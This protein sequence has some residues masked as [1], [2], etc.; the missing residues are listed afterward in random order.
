[1]TQD[2]HIASHFISEPITIH[3]VEPPIHT[4]K[5]HCPDR[6]N[7]RGEEWIITACLAEWVDYT[8]R[9][10][11]AKNMQAQHAQVASQHGSWGV[12]R[13]YFDVQSLQEGSHTQADRFF[14]LYY[15]R[16]P[17]D[18]SDRTGRWVLLA[19]LIQAED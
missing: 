18:A 8:R 19:E 3:F 13:F 14:R 10:R 2:K 11:M 7:W 12:G 17:Q 9:G 4:K 16:A 1:M 5:P 15:D 6:F